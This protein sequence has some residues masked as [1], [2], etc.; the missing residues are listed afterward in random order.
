MFNCQLNLK[1]TWLRHQWFC[2]VYFSLSNI[3]N[4]MYIQ[5]LGEIVPP[6]NQNTVGDC[7]QITLL[8]LHHVSSRLV[9]LLK[10]TDDLIQVLNIFDL[11]V[12]FKFLNFG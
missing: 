11:T 12:S 5:Q 3:I 7:N 10:V 1:G 2:C 6:P 4:P 8:I 9:T